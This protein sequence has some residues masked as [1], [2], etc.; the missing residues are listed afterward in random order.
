[1]MDKESKD[2]WASLE[3]SAAQ[4][5]EQKCCAA[6]NKYR[7]EF[8]QL[9]LPSTIGGISVRLLDVKYCAQCGAKLDAEGR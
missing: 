8:G 1:M 2:L 6:M 4:G 7:S 9:A 5:P 3:K